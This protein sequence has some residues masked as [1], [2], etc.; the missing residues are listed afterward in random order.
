MYDVIKI[1]KKPMMSKPSKE[2]QFKKKTIRGF[3]EGYWGEP[4]AWWRARTVLWGGLIVKFIS[5]SSGNYLLPVQVGAI[6]M[7]FPR[8][9]NISFWLLPPSLILLLLSSLVENGTTQ[10]F[11]KFDIHDD[12]Y[13]FAGLLPI[14]GLRNTLTL[15]QRSL[16]EIPTNSYQFKV[17]IGLLLGDG[18]IHKN[19]TISKKNQQIGKRTFNSRFQYAQ[20]TIHIDYFFYIYNIISNFCSVKPFFYKKWHKVHQQFDFGYYINTI[21]LPC[22]NYFREIFYVNNIKIVPNDIYNLLTPIGLAFLIM[23]DGSYHIKYKLLVLCTDNFTH[24]D[25]LRL[26]HV[27][28]IKFKLNCRIERKKTNLRIVVKAN[29][30]YRLRIL[31]K[32]HIHPS[33]MYK[34]G[35]P[36]KNLLTIKS[37]NN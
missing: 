27:L 23:D 7:A 17:F 36:N 2:T 33:M 13:C 1:Y 19:K 28:Q 10:L 5:I 16:F 34:L 32:D 24:S 35:L 26:M 3:F 20:S 8:L 29:S 30:M 12:F 37:S 21:T 15:K 18:H 14:L 9:N 22:F 4:Y 11:F 31:V 25:V 6:D